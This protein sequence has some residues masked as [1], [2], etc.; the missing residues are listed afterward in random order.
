MMLMIAS[1]LP[2]SISN[3]LV[4]EWGD[5]IATDMPLSA[6]LVTPDGDGEAFQIVSADEAAALVMGGAAPLV[7]MLRRETPGEGWR[8]WMIITATLAPS[9]DNCLLLN[10]RAVNVH[11]HAVQGALATLQEAGIGVAWSDPDPERIAALT[12]VL[13]SRSRDALI[14]TRRLVHPDGEALAWLSGLPGVGEATARAALA[15]GGGNPAIALCALTDPELPPPAGL[16]PRVWQQAQERVRAWLRLD[17]PLALTIG[18]ET[19]VRH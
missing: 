7:A 17:A 12:R 18:E 16:S 14:P 15:Y 2:R 11:W 5:G 13:A 19:D 4:L 6:T 3:A 8:R 10:G 9:P 1:R